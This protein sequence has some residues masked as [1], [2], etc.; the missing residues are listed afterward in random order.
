MPKQWMIAVFKK[1]CFYNINQNAGR[2][3]TDQRTTNILYMRSEQASWRFI[4]DDDG[5]NND[6]DGGYGRSDGCDD[7]VD[8]DGH[9]YVSKFLEDPRT[10]HH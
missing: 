3:F 5:D 1:K 2:T 7:G 6:G 8:G 9:G 4:S 10:G